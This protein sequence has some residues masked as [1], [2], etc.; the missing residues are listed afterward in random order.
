MRRF[1][2]RKNFLPKIHRLMRRQEHKKQYADDVIVLNEAAKSD[3]EYS[4]T[5]SP[6]LMPIAL[7]PGSEEITRLETGRIAIF[8]GVRRGFAAAYDALVE[9]PSERGR[10]AIVAKECFPDEIMDYSPL[11]IDGRDESAFAV[12]LREMEKTN[13]P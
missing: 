10:G 6:H 3:R 8:E 4:D 13:G 7:P 5:S 9:D 12:Y 2:R 1:F 11:D